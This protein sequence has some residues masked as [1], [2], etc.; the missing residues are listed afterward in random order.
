[1]QPAQHKLNSKQVEELCK[2]LIALSPA[3]AELFSIV[4]VALS[5]AV[6]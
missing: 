6:Q 5:V 3:S 2:L 4:L 1:M